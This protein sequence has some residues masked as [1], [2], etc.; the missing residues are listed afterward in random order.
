LRK[1]YK[2][3]IK[4]LHPGENFED[5]KPSGQ[6]TINDMF[7]RQKREGLENAVGGSVD[8][9]TKNSEKSDITDGLDDAQVLGLDISEVS[10][11]DT[12]KE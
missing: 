10:S 2:G 9:V 1:N 11:E 12:R 5:L 8:F 3:H 7:R 4:A 6:S